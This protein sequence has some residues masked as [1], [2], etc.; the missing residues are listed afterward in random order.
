MTVPERMRL[1]GGTASS[2]SAG[3]TRPTGAADARTSLA[4]NMNAELFNA[5]TEWTILHGGALGDVVL[6]LQLALRIEALRR[7]KRILLVSRVSLGNLSDCRPAIM[8]QSSE[9]AALSWLY[10]DDECVPPARLYALVH[11]RCVLNALG[12]AGQRA[13]AR[14]ARLEP[15]RVLSIDPRPDVN[16]QLHITEQ[17]AEQLRSQ[18]VAL[19]A[20]PDRPRFQ[21]PASMRNVCVQRPIVIHP[22]SGGRDKCWPLDNF[23][24][25]A[26]ELRAAG[27]KVVFLLGEAELERWSRI[28]EL[29][30][31]F[32]L[33]T[34]PNADTLTRLLAECALLLGNDSGPS[35][36]AALVAAPTLTLFGPTSPDVWRPLGPA[37][38]VIAGDPMHDPRDWRI[39]PAAV[40]EQ[41][42]RVLDSTA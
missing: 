22:G 20:D 15:A 36:L 1:V 27:R 37:A 25:V 28:D 4:A 11:D 35:H 2:E 42:L 39:E 7:A 14:L 23:I 41:V 26:N 8:H 24:T 33:I 38:R 9:S 6:T 30:R 12:A 17:W 18:S 40:V 32:S 31:A 10:R 29:R 16:S 5:D 3:G 34:M 13:Q 19:D 21:T